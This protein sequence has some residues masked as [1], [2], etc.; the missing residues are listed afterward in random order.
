MTPLLLSLLLR[1]LLLLLL[2]PQGTDM[3]SDLS[4][5]S[6]SSGFAALPKLQRLDLA[7]AKL[8]EWA[9]G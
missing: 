3:E 1:P 2:S 7:G 9:A 6:F 8:G 5:P 4:C